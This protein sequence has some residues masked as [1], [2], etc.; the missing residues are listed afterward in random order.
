M[1]IDRHGDQQIVTRYIEEELK[2]PLPEKISI[3]NIVSE[4]SP[5]WLILLAQN[6]NV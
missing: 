4:L 2:D 1:K 3:S 6:D 5:D